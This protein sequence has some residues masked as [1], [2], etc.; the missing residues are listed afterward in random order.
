[1]SDGTLRSIALITVLLQPRL[2]SV[3]CIDEPELGLHPAAISILADLIKCASEKCQVI[4]ATQSSA[5][6][7]YF[8]PEDIVVVN[9]VQGETKFERL[10]YETYKDWLDEYSISTIWD[11]NIF[12]GRPQR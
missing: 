1:M 6:I 4:I 2:P 11:T 10:S 7:D 8:L 3:V 9:K 12:G 5:L